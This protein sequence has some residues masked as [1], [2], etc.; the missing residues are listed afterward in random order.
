MTDKSARIFIPAVKYHVL[1]PYFDFFSGL[2]GFGR[3]Y[4]KKVLSTFPA[5]GRAARALDAGC[6]SGSIAILLKK[7][8]PAVRV[9]GVDADA[10]IL[11]Q[12]RR[13]AIESKTTILFKRAFL[14]RLPFS[15]NSFDLAYSSLVFHHLTH[16]AK[17]QAIREIHRVLK[18][19]GTFIL[20]DFGP[21]RGLLSAAFPLFAVL[22]EEGGDNYRG[23]IPLM[24]SE[25]F[26]SVT[27]GG[28]YRHSIQIITA[29]K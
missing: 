11:S 29:V 8:Y 23:K 7:R 22:F 2:L 18:H 6:G 17:V 19:G 20:S 25:R 24:L 14:Q 12:A 15:D 3:R 26:T 21:P 13:K 10:T 5:P 27:I 16:K 9:Y 1:T 28:T 4:Q